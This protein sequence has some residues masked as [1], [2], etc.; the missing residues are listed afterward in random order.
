MANNIDYSKISQ[1]LDELLKNVD[2]SNTS[3]D[4][5]KQDVQDGYYLSEVKKAELSESKSGNPMFTI[6]FNTV[7]DGKKIIVDDDGYAQ[8]EDAKNTTNK[9]L[10]LNY[11][12][13]NEIQIGFFV[14]D[15]LKFQDLETD[16]PFF[17]KEDFQDT[18][19]ILRVAEMLSA[20]GI[21]YLM[22]QTVEKKNEPG[23][24]EK[25]IKPITWKRA[26]KLE[27]I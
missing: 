13:S 12:L 6:E 9:R 10:F 5:V 23:Q 15:M 14:S 22:V 4:G 8:L 7:E 20:G 2:L 24:Y 18:E 26:R 17:T 25:K 19:G 27:L 3:E 16:T 1:T 21:I 11:V